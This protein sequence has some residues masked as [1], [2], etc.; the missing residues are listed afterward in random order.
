MTENTSLTGCYVGC[1]PPVIG[2][3]VSVTPVAMH[4]A[5]TPSVGQLP[6]TG[7]DVF[8]LLFLSAA[9]FVAGAWGVFG[10]GAKRHG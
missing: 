2:P 6:F 8:T 4:A 10:R 5:P 3:G 9:F 7:A 1:T